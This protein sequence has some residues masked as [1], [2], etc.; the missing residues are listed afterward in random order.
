VSVFWCFARVDRISL[1]SGLRLL[2][3]SSGFESVRII[4]MFDFLLNC[5]N[6]FLQLTEESI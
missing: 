3:L 1:F 2:L 4:Y 6:C 5:E